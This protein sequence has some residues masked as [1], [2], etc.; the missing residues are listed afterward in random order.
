[1]AELRTLARPYAEAAFDLARGQDRLPAWDEALN[2]LA[3]IVAHPDVHRLLGNPQLTDTE[4]ADAVIGIAADDLDGGLTN[5]V[6]LLAEKA[7]L[8]LMPGIAEHFAEL[9]A[10]AENRVDVTVTAADEVSTAQQQA[11]KQAL[12]QRLARNVDLTTEVDAELI[13][14]AV[15]RAGDT[16]IDGSVRAH[17]ARLSNV[18]AR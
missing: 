9:R 5:L 12:E 13:G 2:G 15:V 16:V 1:M 4:V 10:A 6:R 7:R 14:G 8:G 3:T 18:V 17:L 11:L